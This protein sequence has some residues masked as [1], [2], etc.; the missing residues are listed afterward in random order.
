LAWAASPNF[1]ETLEVDRKAPLFQIKSQYRKF[2]KMY[3]PD[4]PGGGNPAKFLKVQEAYETLSDDQR[5]A[6]YD[7]FLDQPAS[8]GQ[9]WNGAQ[10]ARSARDTTADPEYDDFQSYFASGDRWSDLF[11]NGTIGSHWVLMDFVRAKLDNLTLFEV[12]NRAG[13]YQNWQAAL[14]RVVEANKDA[15]NK[16]AWNQFSQFGG[17]MLVGRNGLGIA[18]VFNV[19]GLINML[20]PAPGNT[21][22][23]GATVI[24]ASP[25]VWHLLLYLQ[26]V[27][28][29]DRS[30]RMVRSFNESILTASSDD[31]LINGVL[32]YDFLAGT[33]EKYF[34]YLGNSKKY[35]RIVRRWTLLLARKNHDILKGWLVRYLQQHRTGASTQVVDDLFVTDMKGHP[36][37]WR[38]PLADVIS[39]LHEVP[40]L[41]AEA[42]ALEARLQ[43]QTYAG[44]AA[45]NVRS[46]VGWACE[47]LLANWQALT[48]KRVGY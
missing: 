37:L 32:A 3:H 14:D 11:F 13:R 42:K 31:R 17:S 18:W 43:S 19:I 34:R 22:L 15:F 36:W 8:S 27:P 20:A 26:A 29:A 9:S 45:R 41:Q 44:V 38:K 16:L 24:L 46:K 4:I 21:P 5:R 6:Q 28:N 12:L 25:F 35:E 33:L 30:R 7:R 23:V 1:Y 47:F 2:A 10:S 39:D 40:D 48:M